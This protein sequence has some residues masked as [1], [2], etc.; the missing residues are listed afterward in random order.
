MKYVLFVCTHNA[1]RSQMAQAFFERHAPADMHAESAGEEPAKQ[2]WPEVVEAMREAD[3]DLAGR[4]PQKLTRTASPTSFASPA[5]CP[6][7]SG[8]SRASARTPRSAPA[9]TR[10]STTTTTRRYAVT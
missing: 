2:I 5:C 6:A 9:P 1:G 4:R 10:S 3:I 8:G 7:W